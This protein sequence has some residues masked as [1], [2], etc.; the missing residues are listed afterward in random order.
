M[1]DLPAPDGPT[2]AQRGPGGMS[3]SMPF[4]I[5]RLGVIAEAHVLEPDMAAA[6]TVE[7]RRAGAVD[8]LGRRVEQVPHRLHVDQAL[9]DRAIDPAEHVER[10]EELHQ[11]AVDHTTSPA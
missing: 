9:A 1:V 5:S 4:R 7:R 10:A 2:T 8:D 6:S 11:Q 3:R